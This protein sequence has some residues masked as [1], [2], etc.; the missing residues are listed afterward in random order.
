MTL[1]FPKNIVEAKLKSFELQL[2]DDIS[3]HPNTDRVTWL[4]VITLTQT[5][6]KKEQ[7]GE[8]NTKCTV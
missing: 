8:R 2:T 3:K 4:L 6:N 5:Y 7:G 1:F